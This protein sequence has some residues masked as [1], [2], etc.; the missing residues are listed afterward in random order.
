MLKDFINLLFPRQCLH[1]KK[2]IDQDFLC[3]DCLKT[4]KFTNDYLYPTSSQCYLRLH[5][6][7]KIKFGMSMCLFQKKTA[8]RDLMH[9]L[10]Y[11]HQPKIGVWLGKMC[12]EK[13]LQYHFDSH[14]DLIIPI[15]LHM[16]RLKSRGYNQSTMFAK[17]L[18]E[19]LNRPVYEDIVIRIKNTPTQTTQHRNERFENVK[20]SF[21]VISPQ[22]VEGKNIL[23]VDD[24]ITTGAT[25]IS[26]GNEILKYKPKNLS[27][28]TI[29]TAID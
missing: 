10:K 18:S 7:L 2:N 1:C 9:G 23:L 25:L 16:Q 5:S 24:I 22:K 19:K 12:G 15:P 3:D 6:G 29:A 28:I 20:D 26:C 21:E 17:G 11:G 14:I 8:I 13:L 27:V 4:I